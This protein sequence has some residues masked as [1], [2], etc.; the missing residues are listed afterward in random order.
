MLEVMDE[1]LN[2]AFTIPVAQQ[3]IPRPNHFDHPID[4]LVTF[5]I[6]VIANGIDNEF[7]RFLDAEIDHARA[8]EKRLPARYATVLCR[9][10]I[11]R[12]GFIRVHAFPSNRMN[13]VAANDNSASH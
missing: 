1:F 13:T 6:D 2:S 4:E 7:A 3:Q 5:R 8:A 11:A 9:S 10:F 12:H